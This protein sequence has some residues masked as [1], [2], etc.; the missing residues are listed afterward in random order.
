MSPDT[1]T[2]EDTA[3][4]ALDPQEPPSPCSPLR[5]HPP[6]SR[7]RLTAPVPGQC[8]G[9]GWAVNA[10][11]LKFWVSTRVYTQTPVYTQA[12]TQVCAQPSTRGLDP[13]AWQSG[14]NPGSVRLG[15]A[16]CSPCCVPGDFEGHPQASAGPPMAATL[17]SPCGGSGGRTRNSLRVSRLEP[18]PGARQAAVPQGGGWALLLGRGG[19]WFPKPL[20]GT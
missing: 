13:V 6:V 1:K 5:P 12:H 18:S 16:S 15:P 19:G 20:G 14:A 9:H 4:S 7:A 17:P 2:R 8:Q 10:T 3:F 11:D